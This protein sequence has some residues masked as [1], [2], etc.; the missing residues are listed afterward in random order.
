MKPLVGRSSNMAT[1]T[2]NKFWNETPEPRSSKS[3][4]REAN[5]PYMQKEH[6]E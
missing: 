4:D 3:I 5:K 1:T 2:L 6:I